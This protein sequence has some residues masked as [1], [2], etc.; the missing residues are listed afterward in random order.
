MAPCRARGIFARDK[1]TGRAARLA[2]HSARMGRPPR[3]AEPLAAQP[4]ARLQNRDRKATATKNA[5]WLFL[6]STAVYS[7][8]TNWTPATV[9]TGTAFFG[10]TGV[11]DVG[12]SGRTVVGGWTLNAGAPAYTFVVGPGTLTFDGAGL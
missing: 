8:P 1:E 2:A 9:P 7:S 4:V 6:P 11:A 12:V 10:A 3:L 5:T